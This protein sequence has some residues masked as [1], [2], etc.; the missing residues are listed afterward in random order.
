MLDA[1]RD[2]LSV[3]KEFDNVWDLGRIYQVLLEV[4]ST[5]QQEENVR[6]QKIYHHDLVCLFRCVKDRVIDLEIGILSQVFSVW[7]IILVSCKYYFI[8]QY[9][10]NLMLRI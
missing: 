3:T 4:V 1:S 10:E 5:S 7:F 2:T 9:T 8:Q 6:W